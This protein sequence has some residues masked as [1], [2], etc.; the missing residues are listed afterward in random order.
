MEFFKATQ[1][2]SFIEQKLCS[3]NFDS[4]T[5]IYMERIFNC[6]YNRFGYIE[7]PSNDENQPTY[8]IPV[9]LNLVLL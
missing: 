5:F 6:V 3:K 8:L 9:E 4:D 2:I 7:A 1:K